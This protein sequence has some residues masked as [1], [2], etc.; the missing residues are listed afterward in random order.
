[1]LPL[2]ANQLDPLGLRELKVFDKNMTD[3]DGRNVAAIRLLDYQ[4][5][6]MRQHC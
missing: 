6:D 2:A 5:N 4:T 1:M 3:R